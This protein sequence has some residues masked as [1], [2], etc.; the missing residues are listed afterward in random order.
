MLE[1]HGIP[2][3]VKYDA[4]LNEFSI[5]GDDMLE[6]LKARPRKSLR[7]EGQRVIRVSDG[8]EV[9]NIFVSPSGFIKNVET[10]GKKKVDKTEK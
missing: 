4:S 8:R 3:D 5:M 10:T 9:T 6:F 2:A 1:R 7:I